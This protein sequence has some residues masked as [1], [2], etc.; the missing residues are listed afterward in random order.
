MCDDGVW[1]YYFDC[2]EWNW[3]EGDCVPDMAS[4]AAAHNYVI[5]VSAAVLFSF[6]W[7]GRNVV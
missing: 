3:D 6:V 7:G 5:A 2:E 1:G 4:M